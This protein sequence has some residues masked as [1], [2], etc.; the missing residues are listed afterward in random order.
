MSTIIFFL[1]CQVRGEA[2]R[3]WEKSCGASQRKRGSEFAGKTW[4]CTKSREWPAVCCGLRRS[5]WQSVTATDPLSVQSLNNPVLGRAPP[6]ARPAAINS[7]NLLSCCQFCWGLVTSSGLAARPENLETIAPGQSNTDLELFN[8]LDPTVCIQIWGQDDV[9]TQ[10]HPGTQ[11]RE[12]QAACADNGE[13]SLVHT[14]IWTV[15]SIGYYYIW[16]QYL[17]I[18]NVAAERKLEILYT[19]ETVEAMSSQHESH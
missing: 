5:H 6:P 10:L 13:I 15:L 17:A 18:H 19:L 3:F 11:H 12:T 2:E 9:A 4:N 7:C 16:R 8:K 1:L 14:L